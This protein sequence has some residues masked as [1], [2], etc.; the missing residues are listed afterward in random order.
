MSFNV[1]N[2]PMPE[3]WDEA[4]RMAEQAY[5]DRNRASAPQG[6]SAAAS[7]SAQLLSPSSASQGA[8]GERAR[9][10]P[11]S[12]TFSASPR[13]A[14]MVSSSDAK[15][16]YREGLPRLREALIRDGASE[17]YSTARVKRLFLSGGQTCDG[18]KQHT[19]RFLLAINK[20]TALILGAVR[21]AEDEHPGSVSPDLLKSHL[22]GV[23]SQLNSFY[24]KVKDT[25]EYRS[26][27]EEMHFNARYI[28]PIMLNDSSWAQTLIVAGTDR[29]RDALVAAKP[30][31][32]S[33]PFASK[34][35]KASVLLAMAEMK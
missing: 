32:I 14:T 12:L 15:A 34:L 17:F 28:R 23:I 22:D 25:D 7:P 24:E 11:S 4:V 13:A 1:N 33:D 2:S 9:H 5:A 29:P 20:M 16:I 18:E 35:L 3:S 21:T 10:V 19:E 6:A 31:F 27:V 26:L 8:F 30:W